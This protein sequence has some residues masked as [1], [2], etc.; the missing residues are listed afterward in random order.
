MNH[1]ENDQDG[2]E[3][4]DLEEPPKSED[5]SYI[6]SKAEVVFTILNTF[7]KKDYEGETIF[8]DLFDCPT[9]HE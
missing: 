9:L 2:V 5:E 6:D 8:Y 3:D 7:K 1:P 4:E